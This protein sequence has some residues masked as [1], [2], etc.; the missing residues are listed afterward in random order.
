[1]SLRKILPY[2][3]LVVLF[4]GIVLVWRQV[5]LPCAQPLAYSLGTVDSHFGLS[6]TEF[7]RDVTVAETFWENALGKQLFQAVPGAAFK[8]N[9]IYD[10][11]QQR[12]TE[13]QQLQTALETVQNKQENLNQKQGETRVRFEQAGR[14]YERVLSS[15]KR[16]LDAYNREVSKWNKEGGAPPDAYQNLQDVAAALKSDQLDLETARQKVNDA[17]AQ[18]NAFSKQKVTIV[19][20]YNA[21]VTQYN[22]RYGSDP[23]AFEQGDYASKEIDIY[24]FDDEVHLRLVLV[25]ELGHALGLIHGS[26]PTSIMYPLMKDQSL[27]PL[28]LSLEDNAMLKAQ[29]TQTVWNIVWERLGLAKEKVSSVLQR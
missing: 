9:L 29:C 15:F 17:A 12:T 21:Q 18:V 19:D 3:F 25:H 28:T 23:R 7:L 16:R 11:R 4:W 14:D 27:D 20:K 24:Q 5:P 6:E 26:D 22:D 8:I 1:M 13:G 2:V 10:E